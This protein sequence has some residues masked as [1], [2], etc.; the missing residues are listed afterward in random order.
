[1]ERQDITSVCALSGRLN[2]NRETSLEAAQY[3]DGLDDGGDDECDDDDAA[4]G[5]VLSDE[6]DADAE[7]KLLLLC[8]IKQNEA[9]VTGG[10][11]VSVV[12][13]GS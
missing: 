1:M 2:S 11:D 12:A 10:K 5:S 7:A 3:D 9:Y 6:E 8:S 13:R 4:A